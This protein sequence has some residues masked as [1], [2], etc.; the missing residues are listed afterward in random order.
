MENEQEQSAKKVN[1]GNTGLP[2]GL[3]KR[4]NITLPDGATPRDAWNALEGKG[5]TPKS[6]YESLRKNKKSAIPPTN[7][8]YESLIREDPFYGKI[9]KVSNKYF[10]IDNIK[11]KDHI[12]LLTK[13]IAVV[14]DNLVLVTGLHTAV[15][16]K[17]WQARKVQNRE[18]VD[19]WAVKLA[20]P[21]F[22]EYTFKGEF[23]AGEDHKS[24]DDL[25]RIAASQQRA[26]IP[27]KNMGITFI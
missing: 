5:I 13:N 3:C 22:K 18:G 6:V 20:R 2:F 25:F 21:Y 8:K 1:H 4:Y 26:G 19:G 27:I 9:Q 12:T 11:D 23:D 16:L 15:Y 24:F 10:K 14:K 17:G 7:L